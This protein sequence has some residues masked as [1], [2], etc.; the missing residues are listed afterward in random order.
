M[1]LTQS[2]QILQT[3]NLK[4]A[5]SILQM[6]DIF[7][8]LLVEY[9]SLKSFWKGPTSDERIS[10]TSQCIQRATTGIK[11]Y[12]GI[13]KPRLQ[14]YNGEDQIPSQS[15]GLSAL[16]YVFLMNRPLNSIANTVLEVSQVHTGTA[17]AQCLYGQ[18]LLRGELAIF[19]W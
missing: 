10:D 14:E 7:R 11:H 12:R 1:I 13:R 18:T 5:T 15:D 2:L 8:N 17:R 9:N 4:S 3:Q 19:K 6:R 16:Y